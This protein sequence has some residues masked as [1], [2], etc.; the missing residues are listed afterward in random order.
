MGS[1][2]SFLPQ[3]ECACGL[4][5]VRRGRFT[6]TQTQ[7]ETVGESTVFFDF[8]NSDTLVTYRMLGNEDTVSQHLVDLGLAQFRDKA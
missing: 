6:S 7:R 8:V 4:S 3:S 1:C 5:R 2:V